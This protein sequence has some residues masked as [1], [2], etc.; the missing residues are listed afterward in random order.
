[1]IRQQQLER[2]REGAAAISASFDLGLI[3]CVSIYEEGSDR[4]ERER[5][6]EREVR[7]T[8]GGL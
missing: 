4:R 8:T 1:L 5:E 2:G 3:V 6:R 7:K